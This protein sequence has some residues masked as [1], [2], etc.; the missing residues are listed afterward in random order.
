MNSFE[1][2]Y[3]EIK[4]SKSVAI[5]T[6]VKADGDCLGSGLA[7]YYA[8]EKLGIKADIFNAEPIAKNFSFLTKNIIKNKIESK[9]DLY[10][11]VDSASPKMLGAFS[12]IFEDKGNKTINIDHHTSNTLYGKLFYVKQASSACEIIYEYLK[13]TKQQ[14]SDSMA[15]ALLSGICTDTGCFKYPST[16]SKTHEI[17]SELYSYN[18]DFDRMMFYLFRAMTKKQVKLTNVILNKI[19]YYCND[20]VVIS[21][22][23]KK[24]ILDIQATEDDMPRMVDSLVG[25]EGVEVAI[26][27]RQDYDGGFKVSFRSAGKV[28]VNALASCFGGGGH[29]M[30]SGC[31]IYKKEDEVIKLLVEKAGKFVIE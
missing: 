3:N 12:Y 1:E 31:K 11:A 15:E 6:H 9:Y 5:F 10:I 20:K 8:I 2:I 30:A 17:A 7:L 16:T 26:T 14:L 22:L 28:D 25:I 27:Y 24:E 29:T 19:Q 23:N 4:N 21:G 13:E 18:I